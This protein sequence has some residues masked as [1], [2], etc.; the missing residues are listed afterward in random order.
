MRQPGDGYRSAAGGASWLR[1]LLAYALGGPLAASA[2]A[3]R[4]VASRGVLTGPG[5]WG[6]PLASGGSLNYHRVAGAAA[7]GLLG[8]WL[9]AGLVGLRHVRYARPLGVGTVG[10]ARGFTHGP[11]PLQ[12]AVGCQAPEGSCNAAA[13]AAPS[14]LRTLLRNKKAPQA[15]KLEGPSARADSSPSSDGR[16]R[17]LS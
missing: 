9:T 1:K 15:P 6:E 13:V 17:L 12:M 8:V 16:E 10:A 11:A 4:D 7:R 14:C 3:P 2:T 5:V